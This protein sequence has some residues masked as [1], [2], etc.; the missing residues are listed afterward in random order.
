MARTDVDDLELRRAQLVAAFIAGHAAATA[1]LVE[2]LALGPPPR[3][4]R[5]RAALG[6][7]ARILGLQRGP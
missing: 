1:E 3:R 7:V 6:M 5:A 4:Q 2:Q